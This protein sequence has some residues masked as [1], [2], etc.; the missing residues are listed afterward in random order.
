M[1]TTAKHGLLAATLLLASGAASAA[2]YCTI[3]YL[4]ATNIR[5][6]CEQ[7]GTGGLTGLYS[8]SRFINGL[9][10]DGH[11]VSRNTAGR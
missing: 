4:Y 3:P 5:T 10:H 11:K 6:A 2:D 7:Y 8:T 9:L 1:N